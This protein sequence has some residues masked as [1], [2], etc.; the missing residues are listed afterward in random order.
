MG[1]RSLCARVAVA[2][3]VIAAVG[4]A[5]AQQAA[6]DT[7]DL[8]GAS[9]S[10]RGDG[11][12]VEEYLG[13]TAI[14]VRNGAAVLQD[15]EFEN[16]TIEFDVATSGHRSFIGVVFRST[17]YGSYEDFYLRPHQT[18]RFDALQYTPV[19]HGAS[20]WQLYP[21]Y[22]AAT[23]IPT[24]EW[25]HV[26]LEIS[27]STLRAFVGEAIEPVLAVEA[28]RGPRGPGKVAVR[29]FF[30]EANVLELYPTAF[31][32]VAVRPDP[33]N[34]EYGKE[35][36]PDPKSGLIPEWAVSQPFAS[37][38][39]RV[40]VPPFSFLEQARWQLA[41]SDE[42]GRVNLAR[43][44]GIPDGAREGT[45]LVRAL[46]HSDRQRRTPLNFG[47][48]DRVSIF[49]NGELL[50]TG[51]NTYRSR[52]LR[53]LGV[54]TVENDAVVLPLAEGEN[55]LLA[56]VTEAFGGWGW[57]AKMAAPHGVRI[58]APLDRGGA[59]PTAGATVGGVD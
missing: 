15:V 26:R 27:G 34:V 44:G 25:I 30:P 53:Y 16:G 14:R 50:Y 51:N 19:W 12:K 10:L 37:P 31:S 1:Y 2:T 9:W 33:G 42:K 7:V 57:T 46:I 55:E 28:M 52:S 43:Y 41:R 35:Q 40:E 8:Y 22:N 21:E 29:G 54:M 23:E 18:G 3:L 13:R 49:L 38:G 4:P 5:A 58:S 11:T 48:S 17:D 32:N 39:E 59:G 47:F 56:V 6:P 20:A 45:V 24:G 36:G